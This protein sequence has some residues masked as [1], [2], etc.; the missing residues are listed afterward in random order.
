M[1]GFARLTRAS[2]H[3]SPRDNTAPPSERDRNSWLRH[4][5]IGSCRLAQRPVRAL[6]PCRVAG[7]RIGPC[8]GDHAPAQV[9]FI[10]DFIFTGF[11]ATF[12]GVDT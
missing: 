1:P 9:T 6:A 2:P 5:W 12:R 11:P 7:S 4:N 3:A 8:A 10:L